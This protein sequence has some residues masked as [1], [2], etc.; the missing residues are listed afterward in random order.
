[1]KRLV[2]DRHTYDSDWD[3][4]DALEDAC[5]NDDEPEQDEFIE[6]VT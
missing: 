1:M 5:P 6:D 3:Y 2:K 4:F